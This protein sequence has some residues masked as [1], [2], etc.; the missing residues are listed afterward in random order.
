MGIQLFYRI[1]PPEATK[2]LQRAQNCLAEFAARTPQIELNMFSRCGFAAA[3]KTLL[4]EQGRL[5]GKCLHLQPSRPLRS[6]IPQR[7]KERRSAPFSLSL[8]VVIA[9]QRIVDVQQLVGAAL[10]ELVIHIL[11]RGV[12]LRDLEL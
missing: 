3:R 6:A 10:H 2:T 4:A 11:Q 1:F 9:V 5:S 8:L 12:L 7:K